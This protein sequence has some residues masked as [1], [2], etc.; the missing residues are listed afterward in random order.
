M[1]GAVIRR[2]R[3][4]ADMSMQQMAR[5]VG[6]S[7]PYLSQIERGLRAPSEAVA[8]GIARALG[9]SLEQLYAEAGYVPTRKPSVDQAPLLDAIQRAE[10]LTA[11][12]RKSLAEVYKSFVAVNRLHFTDD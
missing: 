7:N 9:V 11:G 12:Q 3:E 1:L 5:I 6:I 4:M 2:Q 10:E 8:G